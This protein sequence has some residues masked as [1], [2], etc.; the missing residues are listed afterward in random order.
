[1]EASPL[2]GQR[3]TLMK[4]QT[5]CSLKYQPLKIQ[6]TIFALFSLCVYFLESHLEWSY[7]LLGTIYLQNSA[8]IS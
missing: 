4:E 6:V 8:P 5:H 1:M 2:T 3:S 7:T